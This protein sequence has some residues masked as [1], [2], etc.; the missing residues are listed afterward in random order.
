VATEHCSGE[1]RQRSAQLSRAAR[2]AAEDAA[3]ELLGADRPLDWARTRRGA[4]LLSCR[5]GGAAI[6]VS[7]AHGAGA[8][9]GLVGVAGEGEGSAAGTAFGGAPVAI[10]LAL[11]R[12][13][14][15]GVRADQLSALD[16]NLHETSHH[17][18][19]TP[20]R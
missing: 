6:G 15:G 2:A 4:P 10:E 20:R 11:D 9:V 18:A 16:A 5:S 19:F 17:P 3:R 13:L 7:L 12:E 14:L 1:R 8:A